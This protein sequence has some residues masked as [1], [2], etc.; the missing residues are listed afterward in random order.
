MSLVT[1]DLSTGIASLFII[2]KI[3]MSVLALHSIK[4]MYVHTHTHTHNY[5]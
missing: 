2:M 5:I 4:E 3:M 1:V